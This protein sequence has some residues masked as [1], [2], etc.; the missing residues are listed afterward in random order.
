MRFDALKPLFRLRHLS[1]NGDLNIM[2]K[3]QIQVDGSGLVLNYGEIPYHIRRAITGRNRAI[4][5]TQDE[6]GKW[7]D[8]RLINEGY[9]D[10]DI[11]EVVLVD[12][13]GTAKAITDSVDLSKLTKKEQATLAR[14]LKKVEIT[15]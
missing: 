9:L 12:R 8:N 7:G 5:G 13:T 4:Y 15:A 14:L 2:K 11:C 6:D 1:S 10:T 3:V